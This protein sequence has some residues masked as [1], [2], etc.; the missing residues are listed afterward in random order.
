MH[1]IIGEA[2]IYN[3]MYSQDNKDN[4]LKNLSFFKGKGYD[5][6]LVRFDC[7]EDKEKLVSLLDDIVSAGF[8]VFATYTG[9][10]NASPDWNPFIEPEVI[11]EYF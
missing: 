10:D 11:D 8:N 3:D 5:S 2:W 9:Q 4:M 1:K 6:V 7:S